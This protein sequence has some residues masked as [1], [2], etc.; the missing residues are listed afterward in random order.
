MKNWGVAF[1]GAVAVISV[2]F[3]F[4]QYH[5]P[6]PA[7]PT[8]APAV[9]ETPAP[10]PVIV[11]QPKRPAVPHVAPAKRPAPKAAPHV[12][13]GTLINCYWGKIHVGNLTPVQIAAIALKYGVTVKE[14]HDALTCK[15]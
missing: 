11:V 2:A 9:I 5:A 13:A 3:N 1:L 7:A 12:A 8:P 6:L 4:A 10:A 14:V 15:N